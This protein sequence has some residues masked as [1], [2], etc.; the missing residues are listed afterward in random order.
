MGGVGR[1]N[2]LQSGNVKSF[3][4]ATGKV[5]SKATGDRQSPVALL[6]TSDLLIVCTC[7]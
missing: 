2:Q 3:Q 7:V 1:V 5:G 6:P 4:T